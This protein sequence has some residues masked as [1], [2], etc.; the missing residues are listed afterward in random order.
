MPARA[1]A[2]M[3]TRAKA[4]T[5][6]RASSC[7]RHRPRPRPRSSELLPP[8]PSERPTPIACEDDFRTPLQRGDTSRAQ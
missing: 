8:A 4:R 1:R 5:P 2:R 6:A 3:P 7:S